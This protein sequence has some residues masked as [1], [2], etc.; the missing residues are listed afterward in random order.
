MKEIIKIFEYIVVYFI[1]ILS[2]SIQ[3]FSELTAKKSEEKVTAELAK[4]ETLKQS[5]KN[6]KNKLNNTTENLKIANFILESYSKSQVIF[7]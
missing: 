4:N 7:S 2:I 6:C 5:T 1:P 3:L